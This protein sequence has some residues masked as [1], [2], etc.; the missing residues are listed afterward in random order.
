MVETVGIL[1]LGYV[2]IPLAL[3]IS[4]VGLKVIGFDIL[5]DRVAELMAGETPI[6]HI[7]GSQIKGMLA[8][9][10]EATTDFARTAE[11]D[12]LIICVPTP[13]NKVQEPDLSF[14]RATME[15]IAS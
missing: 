5:P 11:C 14:V 2:G 1:G 12:A 4:E 3:R 7:A 15:A 8:R 13:L 6:R 9:G 10:F